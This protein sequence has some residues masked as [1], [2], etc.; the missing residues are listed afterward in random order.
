MV[1][2][3]QKQRVKQSD[4]GTKELKESKQEHVFPPSSQGLC[5]RGKASPRAAHEMVKQVNSDS[6][7]GLNQR[8]QGKWHQ[9]QIPHDV[10]QTNWNNA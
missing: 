3:W 5:L 4:S 6:H 8:T 7:L 9:T 1:R 10:A 2:K